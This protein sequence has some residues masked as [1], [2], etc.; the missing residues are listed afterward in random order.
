MLLSAW[1]VSV[2]TKGDDFTYYAPGP[3]CNPS[4]LKIASWFPSPVL[5]LLCSEK[6]SETWRDIRMYTLKMQVPVYR[7]L[8]GTGSEVSEDPWLFR[9]PRHPANVDTKDVDLNKFSEGNSCGFI[10][11]VI[12]YFWDRGLCSPGWSWTNEL[13]PYFSASAP[14]CWTYRHVPPYPA[15]FL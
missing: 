3:V 15:I 14:K 5:N 10:F 1:G 11:L 2:H 4:W 8:V 12:V 13:T 6:P 9:C 7:G